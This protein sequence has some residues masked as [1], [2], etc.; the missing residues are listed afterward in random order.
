M[1]TN[2][3]TADNI[4]NVRIY[5]PENFTSIQDNE[6]AGWIYLYDVASRTITYWTMD[7]AKK[8]GPGSS[9]IFKFKATTPNLSSPQPLYV[10]WAFS[11]KDN[12]GSLFEA[13][14]VS[15][16]VVPAM[17]ASTGHTDSGIDEN[18]DSIYEY[19]GV[20]FKVDVATPGKYY[21]SASLYENENFTWVSWATSDQLFLAEGQQTVQLRFKSSGIYR[22]NNPSVNFRIEAWLYNENWWYLHNIS[23]IT[24]TYS[25]ASFAP[26]PVMFNPPHS[27]TPPSSL[28]DSNGNSY[29]DNLPV[30]VGVKVTKA[31]YYWIHGWLS[32]NESGYYI[33]WLDSQKIYLSSD[34]TLQLA[35]DGCRIRQAKRSG[36]Y[37]AYFNISD[38]NWNWLDSSE[39]VSDTQYSWE[40]FEPPAAS[41]NP[42]HSFA[43]IDNDKDNK[44]DYLAVDVKLRVNVPGRYWLSG[45]LYENITGSY[46][47]YMESTSL[48]ANTAGQYTVRV[49]FDGTRIRSSGIS[50]HYRVDMSL[51]DGNWNW[52]ESDSYVVE[53]YYSSDNFE[54]LGATI[55]S[56]YSDVEDL[57]NNQKFDSLLVIV[58]LDVNKAGNYSAHGYL[59]DSNWTYVGWSRGENYLSGN[60]Q[61]TVRFDGRE[62]RKA[63]A[64]G[65]YQVY[66]SLYEKDTGTY[67]EG[68]SGG[69]GADYSWE[70]FEPQAAEIL[71]V[72]YGGTEDTNGNGFKDFLVVNVVENVNAA[73]WYRVGGNLFDNENYMWLGWAENYVYLP[74]GVQTVQLRLDG[75]RIRK[76]GI[77]GGYKASVSSYDEYW[78][79]LGWMENNLGQFNCQDF[80]PGGVEILSIVTFGE[81]TDEDS[82]FNYLVEN[83][84]L[85]V[86]KPGKYRITANLR[87]DW[88]WID[89]AWSENDLTTDTTVQLRFSGRNI[90]SSR[91]NGPYT[92]EVWISDEMWNPVTDNSVEVGAEFTYENF[93]RPPAVIAS[94]GHTDEGIDTNNNENFDFLYIDV[95]VNVATPG[96]YR[97]SGSLFDNNWMWIDW[98]ENIVTLDAGV[99]KSVGLS[100]GGYRIRNSGR[101]GPYIVELFLDEVKE[102]EPFRPWIPAMERTVYTTRAY[103]PENFETAPIEFLPSFTENVVDEDGGGYDYLTVNVSVKVTT[104]GRYYIGGSLFT[105][106]LIQKNMP[107]RSPVWITWASTEVDLTPG[108][109]S[110]PLRFRGADINRSGENGPY[111]AD[112]NISGFVGG[113]WDWFGSTTYITAAYFSTQFN[114]PPVVILP[115]PHADYGYDSDGDNLYDF[116]V[117]RFKVDVNKAGRYIIGGDLWPA[118]HAM[119]EKQLGVGVQTVELRFSASKIY[120]NKTNG[121]YWAYFSIMDENWKP[122]GW[123]NHQTGNYRYDQFDPPRVGL[124]RQGLVS[125]SPMV[126]PQVKISD[127]GINIDPE[128]DNLYDFLKVD[129][130][131]K[132]MENGVYT[133]MGES[134]HRLGRK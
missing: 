17:F 10:N 77:S 121:P 37:R 116:I 48:S 21:V 76:A 123:G 32:E 68:Y 108:V 61:I 54:P 65:P 90:Y 34:T 14:P 95:K 51:Y 128:N 118:G 67:L 35:F 27:F 19:L 74:I 100:F 33:T 69:V 41:F 105:S 20:N 44:F 31:G 75:S 46:V 56:V 2:T 70:D 62:I 12:S 59:S 96:K 71:S 58:N 114:P 93:Q 122:L 78:N 81:N 88:K 104:E 99:G 8:I 49:L 64:N 83:V 85:K 115:P 73:G 126:P 134:T 11:T 132:V 98:A 130:S 97:L 25:S 23:Y 94:T 45:S 40:N 89:G 30:N 57:N 60:G 18:G 15:A 124:V 47:T 52:L 43:M 50:G 66:I 131:V 86:N 24:G 9:K 92:L 107:P 111:R 55:T 87:K 4:E 127:T 53:N 16:T 113:R 82:Y 3:G 29:A 28:P 79:W 125:S 39:A 1:V 13:L 5:V 106:P 26:P 42:P 110:I 80:E 109:H 6:N 112:I 38:E 101:S 36:F 120:A 22:L 133:V 102:M 72:E 119:E 84:N 63:R 7:N 129:V 117:V 103:I 91:E